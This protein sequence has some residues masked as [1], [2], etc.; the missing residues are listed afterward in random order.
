MIFY[1]WFWWFLVTACVLWYT[2]ITIY[3]A[4]KGG[5]DI[6]Q[7]LARLAKSNEEPRDD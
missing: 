1:E 7:M 5:F 4:V 3:V 2:T 6:K